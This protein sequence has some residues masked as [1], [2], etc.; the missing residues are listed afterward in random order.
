MIWINWIELDNVVVT[1]AQSKIRGQIV[2][3]L[4]TVIV[5]TNFRLTSKTALGKTARMTT[6]PHADRFNCNVN[7]NWMSFL[8]FVVKHLITQITKSYSF[9]FNFAKMFL[10]AVVVVHVGVGVGSEFEEFEAKLVVVVVV[11]EFGRY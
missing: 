11:A 1:H 3:F 7:K 9:Q 6:C 4:H 5:T 10:I 2:T 8:F